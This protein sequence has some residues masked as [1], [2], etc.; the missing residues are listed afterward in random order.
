VADVAQFRPAR[1][2]EAGRIVELVRDGFEPSRLELFIY[3]CHGIAKYVTAQIELVGG[4]TR[5]FVAERAGEIAGCVELRLFGDRLFLN[6]IAVTP[7]ARRGGVAR[8]LLAAAIAAT[9]TVHHDRFE[10]DVLDDNHA[11]LAWYDEL[12]LEARSVTRWYELA[13]E[14]GVPTDEVV[15]SGFAQAM[16]LQRELGFSQLGLIGRARTAS[17]GMLGGRWFRVTDSDVLFDRDLLARLYAID[18]TRRVLALVDANVRVPE[19]CRAL[20]ATQRR[21]G[22]LAEVVARLERLR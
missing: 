7:N 17:V 19:R 3:G 10:L 12:G 2:S 5:F 13:L 4:D 1:S 6:Y 22:K 15:V 16:L 18:P 21:S 8:H 11:A 9:R 14:P 20:A